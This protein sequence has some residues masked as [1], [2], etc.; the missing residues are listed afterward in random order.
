[1]RY[2]AVETIMAA[3]V[4]AVAGVFL[5]FAISHS[6]FRPEEG[7]YSVSAEFSDAGGIETGA[8]VRINGITIGRVARVAI[9][10]RSLSAVVT[11]SIRPDIRLPA[12][13][14][15]S[16]ASKGPLGGKFLKLSPGTSRHHLAA[17][18]RLSRTR[19]YQPL[20]EVVS[21]EIF[22]SGLNNRP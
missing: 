5:A 19:A 16:I 2:N 22:Q 21:K 10:P 6:H 4:L 9:A 14:M 18:G 3:V 15:A 1:M 13:T 20:E 8:D 7:Y 11:M 12:D 17:G